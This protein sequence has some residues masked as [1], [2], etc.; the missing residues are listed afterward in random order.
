MTDMCHVDSYLM[1]PSCLGMKLDEAPFILGSSFQYFVAG[2]C[3]LSFWVDDD[4][5]LIGS[6]GVESEEWDIDDSL[7]WFWY[8]DDEGVICFLDFSGPKLFCHVFVGEAIE[9]RYNN[10]R[11]ITINSM[12][13][14][15]MRKR[16][17]RFPS[18]FSEVDFDLLDKRDL[19]CFMIGTMYYKP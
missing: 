11:C 12:C 14:S 1:C 16:T 9:T 10:T 6:S 13:E 18:F 19:I 15:W 17:R 4:F 7:S 5:C 2:F 3:G 8:A